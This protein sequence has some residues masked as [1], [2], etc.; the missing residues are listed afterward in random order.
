[1]KRERCLVYYAVT[2]NIIC[3]SLSDMQGFDY[4]YGY[5]KRWIDLVGYD[6][7]KVTSYIECRLGLTPHLVIAIM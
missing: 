5:R 7:K 3:N 2:S 6:T 1:M 4:I